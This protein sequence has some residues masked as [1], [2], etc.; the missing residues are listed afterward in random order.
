MGERDAEQQEA[1]LGLKGLGG[2]VSPQGVR[3][4]AQGLGLG[5]GTSLPRGQGLLG[6]QLR[7]K[8]VREGGEGWR[9]PGK[10]R[11]K[12]GE[13]GDKG[14]GLYRKKGQ[15]SPNIL[16][17]GEGELHGEAM[18]AAEPGAMRTIAEK[19][20]GVLA[21]DGPE[22]TEGPAPRDPVTRAN[23]S[24]G[25]TVAQQS[26]GAAEEEE[27]RLE[28]A[29]GEMLEEKEKPTG[30]GAAAGKEKMVPGGAALD[31]SAA[32]KTGSLGAPR[33]PAGLKAAVK[34]KT[35][36]EQ[37]G[38]HE[39]NMV[40]AGPSTAKESEKKLKKEKEDMVREAL[41]KVELGDRVR[42]AIMLD[43]RK[44]LSEVSQQRLKKETRGKKA[45]RWED[46]FTW[47]LHKLGSLKALFQYVTWSQSRWLLV[48]GA[49]KQREQR[50]EEAAEAWR[51]KQ[52]Q[53]QKAR[54]GRGEP[55]VGARVGR[56][57][58]PF[59]DPWVRNAVAS[60]GQGVN[61]AWPSEE[62]PLIAKYLTADPIH[63]LVQGEGIMDGEGAAWGSDFS[64][65][66]EE[67][68]EEGG[69]RQAEEE[70]TVVEV[71]NAVGQWIVFEGCGRSEEPEIARQ[72]AK[73]LRLG[74]DCEPG[75]HVWL[76]A[77][78][79]GGKQAGR[80][81]FR[82]VEEAAPSIRW[83][84]PGDFR[85]LP[86]RLPRGP[87]FQDY[88]GEVIPAGEPREEDVEAWWQ[89]QAE[90][91][92][93]ESLA[94]GEE[95]GGLFESES[96]T[97]DIAVL[98]EWMRADAQGVGR[99]YE[100]ARPPEG[101]PQW[102]KEMASV[103]SCGK[104]CDEGM[105]ER[106]ENYGADAEILKWI[107]EGGYRI[108]VGEGGKGIKQRNS[109]EARAHP[110]ALQ[111]L[112]LEVLVKGSWELV[113]EEDLINIIPIGLAP[114]PSK[115]PPFRL[116]NDARLVNEHVGGWKFR[117][118]S[119]NAVPLVVNKGDWMFTLDLE[120][121]YYS[122]LLQEESRNLFGGK[123]E[124][125][126]EAKQ[127]LAEGG[128]DTAKL[129]GDTAFVRPKGLP[130]GFKNS[131]AIWTKI[132]R[133]LTRKW[134]EQ[135]F[136]LI[137]YMDDL[138][139]SAPT[140]EECDRI[141]KVVLKDIIELG[142][143]PSWGKTMGTASKRVKFLGVIVDSEEMKFY[144]P[145]ERLDKLEAAAEAVRQGG[146]KAALRELAS[147]AGKVMS[148]SLAIPAAR[149]LTKECY[150]LIRP[151]EVGWEGEV[152]ITAALKEE[153]LE[154][155]TKAREW[156]RRGAPIRRSLGALQLR[157][158]SDASPE[159]Y[160]YRLDGEC[161]QWQ[162]GEAGL[163][164]ARDWE[165]DDELQ[166]Q[167][168]RE[169]KGLEMALLEQKEAVADRSVLLLSDAKAAVAYIEN[170]AGASK[171]MSTIM[172]RIFDF[173][174]TNNT[175]LR[176]EWVKGTDMKEAGVD[177]LSRWGEFQVRKGIFNQLNDSTKWG[178]H[179][180]AAG[181]TVDLYAAEQNRHCARYA[182][183]GALSEEE[184]GSE[185]SV[186]DARCFKPSVDDNLWVCPPTSVIQQA[187]QSF[188]GMNARGTVVVP[189]WEGQPWYLYLRQRALHSMPIPWSKTQPAMVD[190]AS[191]DGSK[192]GVDAWGFRAFF[193][194]NRDGEAEVR[195]SEEQKGLD[196]EG[197]RRALNLSDR[198]LELLGVMLRRVR[199]RREVKVLDIC[200]GVASGPWAMRELGI[201]TCCWGIELDE[202]ARKV[203]AKRV[204]EEQQLVPHD[205]W[206]WASEEGL[207]RIA[208]MGPDLVVAGFP[209]QSVSVAAPHGQ[210][211][212]GKSGVFEA[213]SRIVKA[214][215]EVN[216]A[217]HF[218]L[219]CTDFSTRHP[220]DWRYVSDT[221]GVEPVVICASRISACCRKRAYWASFTVVEPERVEVDPNSVLEAG[222]TSLW[223]KLPTIVASGQ[224]SWNTKEVVEDEWG[225]KL[226]LNIG[227]ME[228]AM[229]FEEGYTEAE[230]LRMRDRFRLVGNAFHVGVLK[231]LMLCYVAHLT[232]R[233]SE[234]RDS[235]KQKGSIFMENQDGP[236]AANDFW[237]RMVWGPG[238]RPEADF[239]A[240]ALRG[241]EGRPTT[242]HEHGRASG[243]E[244]LH[245]PSPNPSRRDIW[246]AAVGGPEEK[247]V[248]CEIEK[249]TGF[250]QLKQA[251]KKG[252]EK[253][254]TK[255]SRA[256]GKTADSSS[257]TVAEATA[258]AAWKRLVPE[259]KQG[260]A[261]PP[262]S[263]WDLTQ[264]RWQGG[265]QPKLEALAWERQRPQERQPPPADPMS[266]ALFGRTLAD[267][268]AMKS[269]AGSTWKS[270]RAWWQVLE[271]FG[272]AFGVDTSKSGNWE[273][274]VELLR[275]VV[276]L[277]ASCYGQST[278]C[279]F[280]S[281]VAFKFSMQNFKKPWESSAFRMTMEGIKRELG[282]AV[283]K[284]PPL[285]ACHVAAL[286][287]IVGV[288][289]GW[290][291]QQ[292][293]QG[294]AMLSMGWHLFNRRQDFGRLQPC[295]LRIAGD[296][297]QVLIRYAKNDV[298]GKT[299]EPSVE[300]AEDPGRCPVEAMKTYMAECGIKVQLGCDKK[301]GEPYA[302]TKCPPLF[303]S[304]W[305]KGGV[306]GRAMPDS[307]VSSVIKGLMQQVATARPELLTPEEAKKFSA[308][309]MRCGGTSEAA[310]Q[311]VRDGVTFAHGGWA[312]RQSLIHY[313]LMKKGEEGAVSRALNKAVRGFVTAEGE[314]PE[315]NL[316]ANPNLAPVAPRK[317]GAS[318]SSEESEESEFT[319][320][321]ILE[322]RGWKK[323]GGRQFKV[324]WTPCEQNNYG[325]EQTWESEK[326][327]RADG[328][329]ARLDDFLR[330][331]KKL[332]KTSK[333]P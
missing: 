134:R 117:Y 95:Q 189:D 57:Q 256:Q 223:E 150:S 268:Y 307:R 25:V 114:K 21:H 33:E 317:G 52:K 212:R 266:M 300:K 264:S 279:I 116:I 64:G 23:C 285:E 5:L 259:R 133:T 123:L 61:R 276:A 66:E 20:M 81:R 277:L 7:V 330:D 251:E 93:S 288:P 105:L 65:G 90:K 99:E 287:G 132:F 144:I 320:E 14:A 148:M 156:N 208:A 260:L 227:E 294:K 46:R 168:W 219:E 80:V 218:L 331:Q 139:F 244:P 2:I 275:V 83:A 106:W 203:A 231:H 200:G 215:R 28:R 24:L 145:G 263:M 122:F 169:L 313:D 49:T 220:K 262:A 9:E 261:A 199:Q 311:C 159:G 126:D 109:K 67:E 312:T 112:I 237:D 295:D 180:G 74:E 193:I 92:R 84:G 155:A 6:G 18:A 19:Q 26:L 63:T 71:R 192:H 158:T 242:V 247:K 82:V 191:K 48:R 138:L 38:F 211:L 284:Q 39:I 76:E 101:N 291:M 328:L 1:A 146:D 68:E 113:N 255:R 293:L 157:I 286:L 34:K 176:A 187:A 136:A 278:I 210:G 290:T 53:L 316:D 36:E 315:P 137:H 222:R 31:N 70:V 195:V 72:T 183:R 292:W 10:P 54:E 282:T 213:V 154:I 59:S 303:P 241:P 225:E 86:Q 69:G 130:M 280:V 88:D 11:E 29:L 333:V 249:P 115:I 16:V 127:K 181:Y 120:D 186:G 233:R 12:P 172:R 8:P 252:P 272:G 142:M 179:G 289:G 85:T 141:R 149:L 306:R 323:K 94:E 201:R 206:Y 60:E 43:E 229:M 198:E 100:Y 51:S 56:S 110:E 271:A 151:S 167:A 50:K 35:Q 190:A 162:M 224:S 102:M 309:S 97:P 202:A 230:G 87:L 73:D 78:A 205:V 153:L 269:K 299:R 147:V 166:W 55:E 302:C 164:V 111:A 188:M 160:G 107:R 297:M 232:K 248:K 27:V 239:W 4:E 304:I 327:L 209:C 131:C 329:G 298:R 267:D 152:E 194:D 238:G 143:A 89:L 47:W 301:W 318:S 310:A 165:Q 308:K 243:A 140:Q 161:R 326:T 234:D 235:V 314:E 42:L 41:S 185:G 96:C 184:G 121:A 175:R 250:G 281:A 15:V 17:E 296:T 196:S 221:L 40:P 177:S 163:G 174:L 128:F 254:A 236:R 321:K 325:A 44:L 119:L 332:T 245:N 240:Q 98:G 125:D 32:R 182:A 3:V 173:C 274:A 253:K 79:R 273:Q 118:E 324:L 246:E 270:Y 13:V 322:A 77:R 124:M 319:V 58:T 204:P 170:G 108:K 171:V 226:P 75:G 104:I 258:G 30:S 214:V 178:K 197:A 257:T 91:A 45:K 305:K 283:K 129:K 217:A 62:S 37:V 103:F 228:R 265:D 135:G 207:L 22:E 216:P